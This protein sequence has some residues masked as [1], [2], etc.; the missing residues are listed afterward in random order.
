MDKQIVKAKKIHCVFFIVAAVLL[1]A[2]GKKASQEIDLGTFED[3]VYSNTY[4][5]FKMILPTDWSIQDQQS[6]KQIMDSGSEIIAGEDENLKTLMK[7]SE[8]QVVTLLA[9]YKHPL[10]APVSFNPN[11]I[12]VAERVRHIP[13]I[14]SG[15]DYLFHTRKTIELGQL[16]YSFP[17]EI[18]SEN[19]GG[20]DFS[21]M[22]ADVA[23]GQMTVHQRIYSAIIKGYA[24][25]FTVSFTNDEEDSF[26]QDV[27]ESVTQL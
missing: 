9:A 10:G 25:M 22:C 13:G 12:C 4:F 16:E 15:K 23:I 5:G 8:K 3:S 18:Y 20:M 24:L 2:C 27:L 1:S 17:K 19:I 6:I 21:V 26:L 11:I 7:Y 14:K